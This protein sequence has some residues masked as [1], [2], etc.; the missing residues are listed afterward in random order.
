M[1][2]LAQC[3]ITQFIYFRPFAATNR[4]L[5]DKHLNDPEAVKKSVALMKM[6]D[7]SMM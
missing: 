3:F 6:L 4:K 5:P 1:C 7:E 2:F